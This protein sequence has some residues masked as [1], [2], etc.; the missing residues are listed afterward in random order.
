MKSGT[1]E[2]TAAEGHI[3]HIPRSKAGQAG[4]GQTVTALKNEA[5]PTYCPVWTLSRWRQAASIEEGPYISGWAAQ[6][7]RSPRGDFL[8][9]AQPPGQK[10]LPR[11]TSSRRA[12]P[13]RR[14]G[15]IP[16]R[17]GHVTNA[18]SHGALL[19]FALPPRDNL[20]RPYRLR[21]RPYQVR[22]HGCM[23]PQVLV[24]APNGRSPCV[25]V[26]GGRPSQSAP[27]LV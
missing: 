7:S 21:R 18:S 5:D 25:V 1:K 20:R 17:A 13:P 14:E 23:S 6:R 19:V 10:G 12:S 11:D 8:P 3:V 16:L 27:G 24:P 4:E 26:E 2:G 15:G 22:L 9:D